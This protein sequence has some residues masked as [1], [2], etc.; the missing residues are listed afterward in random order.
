M[1]DFLNNK[2]NIYIASL[3]SD[4]MWASGKKS[5]ANKILKDILEVYPNNNAITF[6][7]LK[8]NIKD[9]IDIENSIRKLD[10]LVQ[11]NYS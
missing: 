6:Q 7:L 4:I 11:N 3:M 10:K 2:F 8:N 5:E 1:K 9:S